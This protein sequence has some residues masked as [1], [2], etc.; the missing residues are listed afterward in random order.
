[1]TEVHTEFIQSGPQ[2]NQDL[3]ANNRMLL[4]F[5]KWRIPS[6]KLPIVSDDLRRFGVRCAFEISELGREAEANPPQHM[7]FDSW[8][9]RVD[10]IKVSA[11]WKT[12]GRISAE[13]GLVA[14]GYERKLGDLSRLHQFSKLY[15]FHVP[16]SFFTCPLAMTDG[17]A[18]AIELHG[19]SSLRAGPFRHLISRDPDLF[20]TSGQWMTEKTGGSDV[21][22]TSTIARLDQARSDK[23][24]LF[25]KKWF[26][27]ATTSQMALALAKVEGAKDSREGLSLFFVELRGPDGALKNIRIDRL[28]EKLGTRALPTA[29]LSLLGAQGTLIGEIG[30][31]VKKVSSM[32]NITRLYNSVTA[33]GAMGHA[34]SLAKDYSTKRQAFGKFLADQPLHLQTL[35]EMQTEFEG[36]FLL[37]FH[38]IHLLGKDETG[39]ATANESAVLRLLTPIIKLWSGKMAMSIVSEAIEVFGGAGYIEDTGL[40]RLLRDSQ[41]FSIWEGTT[42]VLSLDA[43]RAISKAKENALTPFVLDIENRLQSVEVNKLFES[44]VRVIRHSLQEIRKQAESFEPGTNNSIPNE[45]IQAG[46]RAFALA[47]ARTYSASL[48][49]EF[50]SWGHKEGVL[51][52]IPAAQRF[53]RKPMF[54]FYDKTELDWVGLKTLV[55]D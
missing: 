44:E 2:I 8:G 26:T 21:S 24:N 18:R 15:M 31:G 5:L 27:S 32:L 19:S 11:A 13:E 45:S 36:V 9:K 4:A 38:L 10:E 1:M 41:V 39:T 14:I 40:P 53:C 6:E 34:I 28:K 48:F 17:A 47:L 23:Y 25:G 49:I 16:S 30:E 37:G 33:I 35:A 51:E 22:G 46:A 43:L 52:K 54:R 7:P 29:E 42:N 3:F 20:W 50:A 12:L 55:Y